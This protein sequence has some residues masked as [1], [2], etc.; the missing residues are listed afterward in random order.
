MVVGSFSKAFGTAA[1]NLLE[2]EVVTAD[3][4]VRTVNACQDPEL[5]FALRGGGR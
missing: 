4:V 3:G 5:F 2:A 1:G